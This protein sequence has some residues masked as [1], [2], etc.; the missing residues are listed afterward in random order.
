MTKRVAVPHGTA[1]RFVVWSVRASPAQKAL[2]VGSS[3]PYQRSISRAA[4]EMP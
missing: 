1:T 2:R 4:M 3:S